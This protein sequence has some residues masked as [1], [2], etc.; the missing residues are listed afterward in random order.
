MNKHKGPVHAQREE[1]DEQCKQKIDEMITRI[2]RMKTRL[3]LV[4]RLEFVTPRMVGT[5]YPVRRYDLKN[6]LDGAM[7]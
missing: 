1:E 5:H 7:K 4:Q 6:L 2:M 3:G